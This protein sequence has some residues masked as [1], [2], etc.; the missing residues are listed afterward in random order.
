MLSIQELI[1]EIASIKRSS[2][3][4]AAS[5]RAAGQGLN[6]QGTFIAEL[7]RGSRTG[8][9]AVSAVTTA[10]QALEDAAA[11]ITALSRTCDHCTQNLSK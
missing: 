4:L 9:Q 11:S 5:V 1:N 10:S 6:H 3:E 8:Q 2:E 7:V